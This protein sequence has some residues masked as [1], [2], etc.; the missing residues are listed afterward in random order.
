MPRW[1]L[2]SDPKVEH[3]KITVCPWM[4]P[5]FS[6]HLLRTHKAYWYLSPFEKWIVK[7]Y[8]L[9]FIHTILTYSCIRVMF[10]LF[11][12]SCY[13]F[14]RILIIFLLSYRKIVLCTVLSCLDKS[15]APIQK[16]NT[17]KSLCAFEWIL[18]SRNTS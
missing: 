17:L 15:H 14:Y 18:I 5:G 7:T 2:H 11:F 16:L 10:M 1:V 3:V 12:V 9:T 6:K 13:T 8:M 4:G